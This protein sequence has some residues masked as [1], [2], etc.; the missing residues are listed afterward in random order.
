MNKQHVAQ[1]LLKVAKD[2]VA[3]EKVASRK[4]QAKSY[5][6]IEALVDKRKLYSL[7]KEMDVETWAL[8]REVYEKLADAMA[9]DNNEEQAL[10]RLL[11]SMGR[12]SDSETHRNN[13]FKAADLLGIRLPSSMF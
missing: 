1:E 3:I 9:L 10:N 12:T 8:T 7:K 2:L 11:N 6:A 4:R 5:A 13:I